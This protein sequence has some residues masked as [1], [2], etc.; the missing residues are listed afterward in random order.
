[1][2]VGAYAA[3]MCM[4][5]HGAALAQ[6]TQ[7]PADKLY[8]LYADYQMAQQCSGRDLS[9]NAD[10]LAKVAAA[11]KEYALA[12]GLPK[13]ER[14][15]KWE[16]AKQFRVALQADDNWCAVTRDQLILFLPGV[17]PENPARVSPGT[18]DNPF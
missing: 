14:D 7:S 11:I 2:R 16:D 17:L 13:A 8:D 3:I 12:S 18:S 9:F 10:D 1:M 6:E 4:L 5:L 15:Q